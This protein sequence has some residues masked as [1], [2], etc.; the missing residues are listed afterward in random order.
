MRKI[1]VNV[2]EKDKVYKDKSPM[3]YLLQTYAS[4]GSTMSQYFIQIWAPSVNQLLISE[5]ALID[6]PRSMPY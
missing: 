4:F 3:T 2:A 1:T 5:N 6:T